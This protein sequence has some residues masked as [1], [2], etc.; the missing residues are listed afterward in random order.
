MSLKEDT[1]K[2]SAENCQEEPVWMV[3]RDYPE[4][5]V[6]EGEKYCEL[7]GQMAESYGIEVRDIDIVR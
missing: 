1:K 4:H 3:V 5:E 6:H 7:H 2:C